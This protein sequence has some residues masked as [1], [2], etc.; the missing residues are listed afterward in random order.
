MVLTQRGL[1]SLSG[2]AGTAG[3]RGT[4]ACFDFEHDLAFYVYGATA[5][6]YLFRVQH[7][8]AGGVISLVYAVHFVSYSGACPGACARMS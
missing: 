5:A 1:H 2:C 8:I 7:V 6:L 4:V 3:G